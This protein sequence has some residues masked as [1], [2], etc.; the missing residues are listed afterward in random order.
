M[1]A[2]REI[3]SKEIAHYLGTTEMSVSRRM[4]GAVPWTAAELLTISRLLRCRPVDLLPHL[5]SNQEPFDYR[6]RHFASFMLAA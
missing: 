5:D 3:T 1:A 4:R 6:S 2:R